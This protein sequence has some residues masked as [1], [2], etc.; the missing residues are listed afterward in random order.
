M[1][2]KTSLML[3]L[4]LGAVA[5][6]QR[7][8]DTMTRLT[9]RL[10]STEAAEGTFAAE[11]KTMYRAGTTYC[12][13]EELQDPEHGIH[14]LMIVKEPDVWMVNLLAKT[15]R[16]LVDPGPTFNCRLPIFRGVQP[17]PADD[18]K[19]ALLELEFGQEIGYFIRAGATPKPGPVLRD[20]PTRVYATDVGDS[21]LLLF[22][23]GTPERPWAVARQR[24]ETRE[25]FWY[26][27]Y[28]Q[29]PFDA[30]LF[31][32]P[33]GVKIQGVGR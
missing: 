8:P 20:K 13:T 15:A 23:T 14:G 24:G 30:R 28:E 21:Q 19:N 18:M 9:A 11:P 26:D 4:L 17:S 2:A 7:L 25:I 33:G 10:Q 31:A 5:L 22:T 3:C 1:R 29:L 16:H 12:R 27:A 32:K 6:G